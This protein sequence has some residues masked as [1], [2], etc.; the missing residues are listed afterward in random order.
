MAKVTVHAADAAEVKST[1]PGTARVVGPSGRTYKVKRLT[2][3]DRMLVFEAIGSE[4]SQNIPFL[5]YALVAFSVKSIDE[6]E[7]LPRASKNQIMAIVK[8][9]GDDWDAVNDGLRSL[10]PVDDEDERAAI[11]N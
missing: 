5:T 9:I 4:A 3:F 2:P 6:D 11:K 10:N 7:S 8:R 1:E